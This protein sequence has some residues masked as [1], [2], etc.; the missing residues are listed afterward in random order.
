MPL[1]SS[2]YSRPS[3]HPRS[4]VAFAFSFL[5]LAAGSISLGAGEPVD[6]PIPQKIAKSDVRVDLQPI[7]DG[8]ASPV[9]LLAAPGDAS[10]LFVVDQIGRIRVLE[11]G[12][13]RDEP[14]LDVT[15][16]L[17]ELNPDFDERGLLG[18]A[19]DPEFNQAG[20]PGYRRLFTYTSEPPGDHVDFKNPNAG[21]VEPNHHSVVASWRVNEDGARVD[22][23]S[24]HE[25]MR[26]EEPQF[27][28]DGG[29][30][31]FG[32][33]G[34][35]YI[36]L[37]DGGAGNDLGPGH[38]PETGNGQD[39]NVLLGKMLRLDVN[40]TNAANG[41][42]GIPAD[43]PFAKG[44]GLP[45]IFAF[46]LR[47]PWRFSFDGPNLLVG[48]VGQN[49]LEFVH[50][51][52]RGGNYGWRVKEGTFKFLPTG[53]IERIAAGDVPDGLLDPV[54]QYDHDEG[55]TVVGGHVYR[56]K[57][58]P[59]LRGIYVFG[60]YQRPGTSSGR[61]FTGDLATGEIKELRVGAD[62]KPLGFLLKAFGVD[63]DGELYVCGSMKPSPIGPG[64]F[65]K[66][67]V[68]AAK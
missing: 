52:E 58:I 59:A 11:N 38:H 1:P 49:K 27:N 65:V 67:I 47:N 20:K 12:K 5:A 54:L 40:G 25:L 4:I 28:H 53:Q 31:A 50:R 68:P 33:D 55:T 3:T 45:E 36:S 9:L 10:R 64:G 19:F 8:L 15:A 7:A 32:P 30:L 41:A 57:A 16:R 34:F 62:D 35:L 60:D 56:G 13:L 29:M 44:G 63:A 24:R 37:G 26:I 66:K 18:L 51:V 2:R 22:P 39:K 21:G 17:V 6:D 48:D 42:Y 23:G 14:F 46:G 61:L 43:N